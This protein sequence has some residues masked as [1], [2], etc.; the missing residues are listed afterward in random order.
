MDGFVRGLWKIERARNRAVLQAKTVRR[1]SRPEA[2][3]VADEGEKLLA[4]LA[5]EAEATDV[6]ITNPR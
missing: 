4:F 1:L 6:R 2:A 3:A 5:A